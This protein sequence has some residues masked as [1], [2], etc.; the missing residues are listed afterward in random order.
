MKPRKL[1]IMNE[2]ERYSLK[3]FSQLNALSVEIII[4]SYTKLTQF[5]GESGSSR[6]FV[7]EF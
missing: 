3:A 1:E 6:E 5:H 4:L 7:K 2:L